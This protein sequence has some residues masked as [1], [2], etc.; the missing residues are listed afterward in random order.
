MR[1]LPFF[2]VLF[3]FLFLLCSRSDIIRAATYDIEIKQLAPDGWTYTATCDDEQHLCHLFMGIVPQNDT[4]NTND[5]ELDVGLFFKDNG[6]YLQ[7]RSGRDYFFV[8]DELR[9][10]YIAL[11]QKKRKRTKETVTLFLRSPMAKNDPVE[12]L[13]HLPVVR[14]SL[15]MVAE[16]EI[17]II[18]E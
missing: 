6:I 18:A 9:H 4:H 14:P 7:F 13:H 15:K 5:L 11:D 3:L 16:L 17:T 1:L 12:S 8:S 10:F 2:P